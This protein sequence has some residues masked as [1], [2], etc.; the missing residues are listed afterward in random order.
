MCSCFP[1]HVRICNVVDDIP[2]LYFIILFYFYF[3]YL[4][5]YLVN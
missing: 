1:H 4:L 2:I 5:V 3:I